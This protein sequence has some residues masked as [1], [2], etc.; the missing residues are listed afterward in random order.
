MQVSYHT[1]LRTSAQN[2]EHILKYTFHIQILAET[3]VCFAN[4]L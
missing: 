1:Q 2:E 4:F 3:K